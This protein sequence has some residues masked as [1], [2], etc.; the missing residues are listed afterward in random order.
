MFQGLFM[1]FYSSR[2]YADVG[3]RWQG[4]GFRYLLFLAAVCW[5][6]VIC[7]WLVM[8][9]PM[10]FSPSK[11]DYQQLAT[12]PTGHENTQMRVYRIVANIIAQMPVITIQKGKA[13]IDQ[14][15]P[16][17]VY[18]PGTSVP[19]VVID[20][21]GKKKSLED[22]SA[23]VLLTE[24]TLFIRKDQ[25]SA[26]TYHVATLG[27]QVIDAH[28]L[29]QLIE[30]AKDSLFWILPLV[31]FPIE[32]AVS[33]LWMVLLAS[34]YGLA[35]LI[36]GR[37]FKVRELQFLDCF[38]VAA[39]ALT[40]AVIFYTLKDFL[41]FFGAFTLRDAIVAVQPIPSYNIWG[42]LVTVLYLVFAVQSNASLKE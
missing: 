5:G 32:S 41:P 9:A 34:V 7:G 31:F 21:S 37:L 39:V 1:T 29:Q 4:F 6:I 23:M 2:F 14:P 30:Q 25:S 33:F 28:A 18:F 19:L 42:I 3:K 26:Q 8:M 12:E 35:A 15:V 20:T 38:R 40:P 24:E 27:D 13:S 22:T 10:D 16:Y 11:F 36:M 17:T